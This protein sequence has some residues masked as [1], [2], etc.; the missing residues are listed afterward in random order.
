MHHI[1]LTPEIEQVLALN[2]LLLVNFSGGKDSETTLHQIHKHYG[3][4]HQIEVIYS[5][6]GWEYTETDGWASTLRWCTERAAS[7]GYKL[8]YVKN[9]HRTLLEEVVQRGKFPSAGQ[10]WCTA[11]HKRA[12][13]H[14]W[15]TQRTEP[16]ILSIKGMRADESPNRAKMLPW[17][18][19]T[20]ISVKRARLTKQPRTVY[21]WLPV[22]AWPTPYIYEYTAA[23]DLPLHPVYQFLGRFSCQVCIFHTPKDLSMDRKH[24][25]DAFYRIAE[26]EEEI[27]FTMNQRGSVVELANR[28][29]AGKLKNE[30]PQKRSQMCLF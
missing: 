25:P 16:I 5:D 2:P 14:K 23:H 8:H 13:V 18:L 4:T 1:H 17:E 30:K 9:P 22:H 15:L 10:R 21:T 26:L 6:T 29:D 7:Y 11:H 12:N 24:N 27:G 20:M 28:Y 19:D 3:A